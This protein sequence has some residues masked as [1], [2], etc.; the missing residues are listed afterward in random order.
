MISVTELRSGK[1]FRDG[2][3]PF[4]VLDYKHSKLGRGKANI[5][6][7]VRDLQTG[8]ILEKTF[9]S[10]ARVEPI[11]TQK[12]PRQ[13][14]YREGESFVFMDPVSFEQNIIPTKTLGEQAKLLKEGQ[15][16]SVLFWEEKP[17]LVELP[18]SL[19]FVIKETGPGVKG[20]TATRSFKPATLENGVVVKVP[21]FIKAGDKIKVDTRTGEYLERAG[22]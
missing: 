21:L 22:S 16:V 14:L 6:V 5:R 2:G 18:V 19:V 8:A 3:R 17:L 10:G 13:Y 4:L 9:I 20:D 1:T 7:K 12:K 15:D 11:E